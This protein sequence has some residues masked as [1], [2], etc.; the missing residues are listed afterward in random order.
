M[1]RERC[2]RCGSKPVFT[3]PAWVEP[4]ILTL[5]A[6]GARA[7][8]SFNGADRNEAAREEP[9]RKMVPCRLLPCRITR[10]ALESDAHSGLCR[11][12]ILSFQIGHKF[13][14]RLHPCNG[15]LLSQFCCWFLSESAFTFSGRIQ[16]LPNPPGQPALSSH[17]RVIFFFMPRFTSL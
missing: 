1:Y 7:A 15:G 11:C 3:L 9:S 4:T 2:L 8:G 10:R 17:R 14:E 13:K 6:H 16:A 12:A 5:H